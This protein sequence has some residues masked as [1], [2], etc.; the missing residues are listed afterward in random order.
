M[1]SEKRTGS[2][3]EVRLQSTKARPS[4][5]SS[6]SHLSS[7][8][9]IQHVSN[10]QLTQKYLGPKNKRQSKP[11]NHYKGNVSL[12]EAD[13]QLSPPTFAVSKPV[14]NTT[15][16]SNH[17]EHF[18]PSQPIRQSS[19]NYAQVEVEQDLVFDGILKRYPV[20]AEQMFFFTQ[21]KPAKGEVPRNFPNTCNLFNLRVFECDAQNFEVGRLELAAKT[22][23]SHHPILNTS[24]YRNEMI[25]DADVEGFLV[26]NESMASRETVD[27]FTINNNLIRNNVDNRR[28]PHDDAIFALHHLPGGTNSKD[29]VTL[30]CEQLNSSLSISPFRIFIAQCNGKTILVFAFF[31]GVADSVTATW[32]SLNVLNLLFRGSR[33]EE[34]VTQPQPTTPKPAPSFTLDGNSSTKGPQQPRSNFYDCSFRHATMV[35]AKP[36]LLKNATSFMDR[37]FIEIDHGSMEV[38]E[39][40]AM[41]AALSRLHAIEETLTAQ[42]ELQSAKCSGLSMKLQ[43]CREQRLALDTTTLQHDHD[44]KK[45]AT[46][47]W[48]DS[49]TGEAL[50]ISQK[51]KKSVLDSLDVNSS[52]VNPLEGLLVKHSV[53]SENIAKM[54][55]ALSF[56]SLLQLTDVREIEKRE[57][58]KKDARKI[59][60]LADLIR[61]RLKDQVEEQSKFKY[62]LERRIQRLTREL[63]QMN[64]N[65]DVIREKMNTNELETIKISCRL[66]PP[67]IK[68]VV[69]CANV[70]TVPQPNR[71]KKLCN[72]TSA[73]GF[74]PI[75]LDL[76]LINELKLVDDHWNL[77]HQISASQPA[78]S[79]TPKSAAQEFDRNPLELICLSAYTV[80]LKHICGMDRFVIGYKTPSSHFRSINNHQQHIDNLPIPIGPFSSIV[81]LKVDVTK[82]NLTINDLY[83]G[84][85]SQLDLLSKWSHLIPFEKFLAEIPNRAESS[86]LCGKDLNLSIQMEFFGAANLENW[87]QRMGLPI[88]YLLAD[89]AIQ[90][91]PLETDN[92]KASHGFE[93]VDASVDEFDLKLVLMELPNG[94]LAGGLVYR[95]E[96]VSEARIQKWNSRLMSVFNNIRYGSGKISVSSLIG[97]FYQSIW[98]STPSLGNLFV[99]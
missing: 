28:Q 46:W 55:D 68:L 93:L 96:V 85:V 31:R 83:A 50:E 77:H 88:S 6:S 1:K 99:E 30:A 44:E 58:H 63:D 38:T 4:L 43:K 45:E 57:V 79:T 72:A 82:S 66:N 33:L 86:P 21:L 60:A 8:E 49:I 53:S 61:N 27:L 10:R 12:S 18:P 87:T 48:I 13:L 97:R 90:P 75:R 98:T 69:P 25:L 24:F 71:T 5:M 41:R 64:M 51:M 54:L 62:T 19:D 7:L 81:P 3:D 40:T 34:G 84:H 23:L 11:L 59:L 17:V 9:S 65:L 89:S 37:Q 26:G 36:Q 73:Y 14:S 76:D 56:E 15:A 42:K 70:V 95:K 52:A 2:I 35:E 74:S 20:T 67:I 39:R 80:L 32:A 47:L 94:E 92:F 91:W 22:L 78:S 29:S 16:P